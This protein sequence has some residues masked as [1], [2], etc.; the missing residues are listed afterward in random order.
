MMQ[1]GKIKLPRQTKTYISVDYSDCP[2]CKRHRALLADAAF[3]LDDYNDVLGGGKLYDKFKQA[4][5]K[6]GIE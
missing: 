3:L 1:V 4:L 6:E 5:K 2:N